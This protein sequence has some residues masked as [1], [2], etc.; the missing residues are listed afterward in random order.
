LVEQ[1][2]AQVPLRA[3]VCASQPTREIADVVVFDGAPANGNVVA[4]K[5][6]DD[7]PGRNTIGCS[8]RMP[9]KPNMPQRATFR[10]NRRIAPRAFAQ[11]QIAEL[12][13][14]KSS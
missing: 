13:T 2:G 6:R 14:S 8:T 7:H 11:H 1:V 4:W 10:R 12:V 5:R 9:L 3:Q